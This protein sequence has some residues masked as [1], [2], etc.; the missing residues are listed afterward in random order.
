MPRLTLKQA[1]RRLAWAL[2]LEFPQSSLQNAITQR[3]YGLPADYWDTYPVK[4]MSVTADDVQRVA[5]TYLDS[6]GEIKPT[7][8]AVL[9][10]EEFRASQ[11]AK[12]KRPFGY[13]VSALRALGADTDG[14]LDGPLSRMG[15]SPFDYPTPDG[16][17]DEATPWLGTLLWR[18]NFAYE[19]A[20]R[21]PFRVPAPDML[22]YLFGRPPT[23]D[24]RAVIGDDVALALASPAFQRH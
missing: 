21:T 23:D 19:L 15:Q 14:R 6:R 3:L 18:W 20:K 13:V 1:R 10:S 8:A 17:P 5:R 9:R 24:E 22:A 2:Q 16:Y 4:I 7:V 11:G 12:I